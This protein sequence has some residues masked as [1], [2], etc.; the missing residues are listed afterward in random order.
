MPCSLQVYVRYGIHSARQGPGVTG[1]VTDQAG[2]RD[3]RSVAAQGRPAVTGFCGVLF[4]KEN[5]A[6]NSSLEESSRRVAYELI[7]GGEGMKAR[8]AD[9]SCEPNFRSLKGCATLPVTRDR[10]MRQV[11]PQ[12]ISC[13][14]IRHDCEFCLDSPVTASRPKGFEQQSHEIGSETGL[15][16]KRKA[17]SQQ[18]QGLDLVK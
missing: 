3:R 11:A 9:K 18:G 2:A 5:P 13:H 10:Q 12:W 14:S 15:G 1:C 8:G 7:V 6:R 16:A 17:P 4:L